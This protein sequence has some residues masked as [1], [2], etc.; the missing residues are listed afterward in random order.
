MFSAAQKQQA[1]DLYDQF[2]S[3]TKVIL[4]LGYPSRQS[5]YLWISQ[6]YD[7][8]KR[9]SAFRG[10]NTP[11]HPR[12]P[13]VEVKLAAL[14]RC[15][16]LGEDV[17]CVSEEI[18]YSRA[19]IYTWRRKYIQKGAVALMNTGDDPRGILPKGE[20]SSSLE[21]EKLRAQ[22]QDMQLEI[23]ILKETLEVLKKDPGADLTI[24]RNQ[25]KAV[26]VDALKNK[27]SLPILLQRLRLAKSSYYYQH[28][29]ASMP[30]KYEALRD[31]VEILFGENSGRYGYRRIRALLIREGLRISEKVIR[32]I[33]KDCALSVTSKKKKKYSSYGGEIT[34]SVPN[35][36]ERDFH[37][38]VPN[39]KWLTDITEFSI[40]AGKIYLS[41]VV[42]CFDGLVPCWK[43]SNTPDAEL[44]NSMLD[45]AIKML[46][47]GEH[48]LLHTDRGCHYRW[49]GWIS[50][51]EA[52]GLQ[53]SM[54]RKGCSPDNSACEGLF[55]RLKNE[56]FY[57]K[58]WKGVSIKQ[59]IQIL[60]E[61]LIWYNEKRIKVSLGN[62]SPIEYRR[63]LGIAA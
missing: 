12:H 23:D 25:E 42:D 49:P 48:P 38:N 15:F 20:A 59:F 61:Y 53:R 55:G 5:L 16:E 3:I 62:M 56:M 30:D 4:L 50:R 51:M 8:P 41:P 57:N 31:R 60:N 21:V 54:S 9:K 22:V 6:R 27:Y 26:I 45:D 2:K 34:P 37:A 24:L 44:V 36:I 11:E 28:K 40:P 32:R 13:P 35:F 17:Q 10:K 58:D 39:E 29:L 46:K 33:M 14:H 1:L 43:I 19:S 18:G 47:E 52:A 7:P 63:S